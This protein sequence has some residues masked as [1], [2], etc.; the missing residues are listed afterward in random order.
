MSAR[1]ASDPLTAVAAE[2]NSSW[3]ERPP[4]PAAAAGTHAPER[5]GL[6]QTQTRILL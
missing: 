4:G 3:P 2:V 6:R 1:G 5:T